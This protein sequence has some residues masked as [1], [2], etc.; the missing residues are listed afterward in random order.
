MFSCIL[1]RYNNLIDTRGQSS[2]QEVVDRARSIKAD[3]QRLLCELQD[4]NNN[5]IE[6]VAKQRVIEFVYRYNQKSDFFAEIEKIRLQT[7]SELT[8]QFDNV[9]TQWNSMLDN[10]E[11]QFLLLL[12]ERLCAEGIRIG[13][14]K[15]KDGS[16]KSIDWIVISIDPALDEV[17]LLSVNPLKPTPFHKEGYTDIEDEDEFGCA[18]LA[19]SWANSDIRALLNEDFYAKSFSN[20]EK[21]YIVPSKRHYNANDFLIPNDTSEDKVYL[22]TLNEFLLLPP[23]IQHCGFSL[24]GE[25]WWLGEQKTRGWDDTSELPKIYAVNCKTGELID[26]TPDKILLP[27]VGMT[28]KLDYLLS[29]LTENAIW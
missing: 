8:E 13:A 5:K 18:E 11:E 6:T 19:C 1:E 28:V 10:A 27:R 15:E 9:C 4:E 2:L 17:N 24:D 29:L 14:F 23:E 16:E 20:T 22:L 25:A 3:R 26:A 21:T 12:R 7:K